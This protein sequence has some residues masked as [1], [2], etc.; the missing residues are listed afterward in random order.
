M[1]KTRPRRLTTLLDRVSGPHLAL[2][3]VATTVAVGIGYWILSALAPGQGLVGSDNTAGIGLLDGLYFSVVTEATLG[4]GDIRP[5]GLSRAL[6]CAEVV[7][8]LVAAGIAI[9]KITSTT[10]RE[11]RLTSQNAS[12]DWIEL[13]KVPDGQTILTFAL[14]AS[15][16]TTLLYEGENFD[17]NADPVGFFTG[18]LID[19][20][21]TM[22][23]FRY[24]N[25]ASSTT[26][27]DE[28][29]SSLR[30]V[31]DD[32]GQRWIRFQGTAHDYGKQR[33]VSYEGLRASPEASAIIHGIDVSAR[34]Q[35]VRDYLAKHA[36]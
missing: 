17:R 32:H 22:L 19:M 11:L 3:M 13:N 12:G 35:L 25:R 14:I 10:G 30:F 18:E 4:Y 36:R 15:N 16:G 28:G 26:F 20:N 21:E 34:Q 31:T 33:T 24:S 1:I 2:A 7:L 6:A 5:I 29:V 8:G 23:R 9:A 27:F